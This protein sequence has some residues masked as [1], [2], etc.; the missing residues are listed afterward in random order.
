MP[1]LGAP[2]PREPRV[3]WGLQLGLGLGSGLLFLSLSPKPDTGT[4]DVFQGILR[5]SEVWGSL[6]TLQMA[7]GTYGEFLKQAHGGHRVYSI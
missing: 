7:Y 5:N 1:P 2:L 6:G 3:Y 4:P